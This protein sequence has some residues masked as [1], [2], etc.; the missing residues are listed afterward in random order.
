MFVFS[1]ENWKRPA[2][3]INALWNL[4]DSFFLEKEKMCFEKNIRILISGEYQRLPKSTVVRLDNLLQRTKDNNRITVNFCLN[5]GSRAEIVRA[6]NLLLQER[7]Q[8]CSQEQSVLPQSHTNND[9]QRQ[10]D[11]DIKSPTKSHT[12][13]Q[14]TA[15]ISV[16]EFQTHLFTQNIPD[17]DLLIRTGGEQ[18][19]SNFLLWQ[20]AYAE[21]YFTETLWPDLREDELEAILHWYQERQRR[22]GGLPHES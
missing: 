16:E 11:S 22:F 12:D 13:S 4:L 7:S 19:L 6:C 18:R 17:V 20:C 9:T 21:I 10:T 15:P 2:Q 8:H 1:T 5:Y 14:L 3:E